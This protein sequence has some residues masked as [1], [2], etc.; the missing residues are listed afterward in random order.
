MLPDE[1]DRPR[2][3]VLGTSEVVRGGQH[4]ALDAVRVVPADDRPDVR[5]DSGARQRH[6]APRRWG[7]DRID[8]PL[9]H[10]R[11]IPGPHHH[12]VVALIDVD[13]PHRICGD[14]LPGNL[15]GEIVEN[16]RSQICRNTRVANERGITHHTG[17]DH[18]AQP[19]CGLDAHN[20][21][22]CTIA[23]CTCA[24]VQSVHNGRAAIEGFGSCLRARG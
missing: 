2:P 23:A 6:Q 9:D 11:R 16:S 8:L 21:D 13:H 20:E 14:V 7:F 10:D 5:R 3:T 18:V 1:I 17:D 4:R 12:R 22:P 24:E 19:R 15:H